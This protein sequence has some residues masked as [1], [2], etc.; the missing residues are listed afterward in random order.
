MN[1]LIG[2]LVLPSQLNEPEKFITAWIFTDDGHLITAGHSFDENH[3]RLGDIFQIIFQNDTLFEAELVEFTYDLNKGLDYGILRIKSENPFKRFDFIPI[4]NSWFHKGEKFELRGYREN[5]RPGLIT[6]VVGEFM[7]PIGSGNWRWAH[8]SLAGSRKLGG[9]SGGVVLNIK[10]G[11]AVGIQAQQI[12]DDQHLDSLATMISLIPSAITKQAISSG[13]LFKSKVALTNPKLNSFDTSDLINRISFIIQDLKSTDIGLKQVAESHANSSHHKEFVEG[14]ELMLS[15][16]ARYF[17]NIFPHVKWDLTRRSTDDLQ[18]ASKKGVNELLNSDIRIL[19]DLSNHFIQKADA[20]LVD[21]G[22]NNS[23]ILAITTEKGDKN[24]INI[25]SGN[26]FDLL[27][28]IT[29]YNPKYAINALTNIVTDVSID[30]SVFYSNYFQTSRFLSLMQKKD[31]SFQKVTFVLKYGKDL[32]FYGKDIPKGISY[33]SFAFLARPSIDV[34]NAHFDIKKYL[35][36]WEEFYLEGPSPLAEPK[37]TTSV[38]TEADDLTSLNGEPVTEDELFRRIKA[39]RKWG[40]QISEAK[41]RSHIRALNHQNYVFAVLVKKPQNRKQE[42][43]IR[44]TFGGKHYKLY[45]WAFLPG[46]LALGI[47]KCVHLFKLYN[48]KIY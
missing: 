46:T 2:K 18:R 17:N 36:I 5:F 29:Y 38:V 33:L 12:T 6:T 25:T 9:M 24:S 4:D 8:L 19:T 23:H 15:N 30:I 7:E 22:I 44:A 32:K 39:Q 13:F 42:D 11:K 16:F 45:M 28:E 3:S 27:I 10:S 35:A 1:S 31:F 37:S 26:G 20:A 41:L 47:K 40:K 21:I 43:M 14:L 48:I 34:D